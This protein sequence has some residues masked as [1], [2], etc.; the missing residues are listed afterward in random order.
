MPTTGTGK[1][2]GP[3][4][5]N[6]EGKSRQKSK[7]GLREKRREY[8]YPS[9]GG[10][11]K[12]NDARQYPKKKKAQEDPIRL[13]SRKWTITKRGREKGTLGEKKAVAEHEE[14]IWTKLF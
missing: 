5:E 11:E 14:G 10:H 4:K 6:G 1:K 3:E 2:E 9:A 7:K 12:G 13:V 8:L